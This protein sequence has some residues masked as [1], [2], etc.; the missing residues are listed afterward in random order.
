MM[1]VEGCA[2]STSDGNAYDARLAGSPTGM[3]ELPS[4]TF[5]PSLGTA[6]GRLPGAAC[7]DSR[8]LRTTL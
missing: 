8:C 1:S 6:G 2:D 3:L 7:E 5:S 4:A